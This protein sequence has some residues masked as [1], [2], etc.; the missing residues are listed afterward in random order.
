MDRIA[1]RKPNYYDR[2][3]DPGEVESWLRNIEKVFDV[4]EV[5]TEWQVSIGSY[6]LSGKV[7]AWWGTIG[8]KRNELGFDWGSFKTILCETFY[9]V[10][11][12]HKKEDEFLNL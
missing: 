1:V 12:H 4:V 6:Y 3:A 9:P 11:L 2:K 10:S 8:E 7:N 5:P